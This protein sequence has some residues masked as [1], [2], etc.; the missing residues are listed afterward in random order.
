M[1]W[2]TKLSEVSRP[3]LDGAPAIDLNEALCDLLREVNLGVVVRPVT[4]YEISIDEAFFH[5][6]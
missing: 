2:G 3:R 4:T 6:I 1:S 5:E